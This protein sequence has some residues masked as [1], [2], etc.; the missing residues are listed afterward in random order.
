MTALQTNYNAPQLPY[1]NESSVMKKYKQLPYGIKE[2][3]KDE[4][5]AFFIKYNCGA[6]ERTFSNGT[7]V[8]Y[9]PPMPI[10]ARKTPSPSQERNIGISFSEADQVPKFVGKPA[11]MTE[12]FSMDLGTEPSP[13]T[14]KPEPQVP[15]VAPTHKIKATTYRT[16]GIQS[17]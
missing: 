7:V 10:P 5:G 4:E 9:S 3:G 6:K 15:K 13:F 17:K 12:V 2:S 11:Y 1:P 16:L 14:S 8:R